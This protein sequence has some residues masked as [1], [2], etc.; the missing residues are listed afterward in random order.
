MNAS[1]S[2]RGACPALSAPMQTGD[3]LLVRL[4]PMTGGISP[5]TLIGLCEA[6]AR[7]GNG[8][9]EVTARGSLQIR[10]LTASSAP[11]LARDVDALGI[12]VRTGVPV[13]TGPLAGLDPEEIADPTPLA[14]RDPRGDRAG[15]AGEKA[16]AESVGAGR[17]RRP[18]G[19]GWG[20]GGC[21]ADGGAAGRGDRWQLALAGDAKSAQ[22]QQCCQEAACD[23]ALQVLTAIAAWASTPSE[24]FAS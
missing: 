10:G 15:R 6:A 5:K 14:E 16:W 4:H 2:R 11:L 19:A 22:R 18:F 1:F 9:V 23:A 21:E 8:V 7:H 13:E 17:W 24:R 3:G 20:G 12:A